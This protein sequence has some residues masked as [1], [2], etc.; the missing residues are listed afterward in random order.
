MRNH[1]GLLSRAE[2]CW[3]FDARDRMSRSSRL[4]VHPIIAAAENA[5]TKTRT[6]SRE[7][8]F[9][10]RTR[11]DARHRLPLRL[12]RSFGRLEADAKTGAQDKGGVDM[13]QSAVLLERSGQSRFN[14]LQVR[15]QIEPSGDCGVVIHLDCVL[16]AEA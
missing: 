3:T 8:G 11:T 14:D 12:Q 15:G 2:G 1:R 5:Q 13:R 10:L 7:S 4:L 16:V 9:V 6:P